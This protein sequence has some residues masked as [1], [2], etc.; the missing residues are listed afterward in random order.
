MASAVCTLFE[1]NYHYGVGALV[2]SL[3]KTG[4]CGTVFAGYRGHLPDWVT[5]LHPRKNNEGHTTVQ[6]TEGVSIV[7]IPLA[8]SW[9]LTN[10]KPELML[11]LLNEVCPEAE[12]VFYFDPD[13]V[14]LADWSFF[15]QWADEGVAL[16]IDGNFPMPQMHPIRKAWRRYCEPH[17]MKFGGTAKDYYFNGGFL[18][19]ARRDIAFLE[20]WK[21]IHDLIEPEGILSLPMGLGGAPEYKQRRT[22]PFW[23]RDQDALNIAA[24]LDQM[25]ISPIGW[26]AMGWKQPY[27]FMLHA[28]GSP[29]PWVNTVVREAIRGKSPDPL[30]NFTFLDLFAGPV[31]VMSAKEIRRRKWHLRIAGA[32]APLCGALQWLKR[33]Q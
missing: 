32:I 23:L 2:N 27:Q 20:A 1:G 24:D 4:F 17:G 14:C 31:P 28:C 7:F 13:I 33:T 11:Y 5:L 21:K 6:A 15:E 26:E 8:K 18:G 10:L 22:Y 3:S 19:V 29:K 25:N 16:V 12:R 30:M 9:H